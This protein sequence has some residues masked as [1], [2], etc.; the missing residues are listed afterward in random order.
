MLYRLLRSARLYSS[1]SGNVVIETVQVAPL[2]QLF[3]GSDFVSAYQAG[4]ADHPVKRPL[5]ARSWANG[6]ECA[7]FARYDENE[8]IL[9]IDSYACVARQCACAKLFCPR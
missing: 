2:A 1:W 7:K 9:L 8:I 6:I 5:L 4:R 3:Y